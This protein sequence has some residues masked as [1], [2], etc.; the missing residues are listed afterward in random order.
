MDEKLK[1]LSVSAIVDEIE[2]PVEKTASNNVAAAS[3]KTQSSGKC[4]VPFKMD[5]YV[6]VDHGYEYAVTAPVVE[7]PTIRQQT[8]QDKFTPSLLPC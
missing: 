7:S 5:N 1:E 3:P 4:K 6:T 8:H 2:I